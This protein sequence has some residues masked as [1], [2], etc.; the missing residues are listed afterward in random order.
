MLSWEP[1]K[2]CAYFLA[3]GHKWSRAQRT[4]ESA[5]YIVEAFVWHEAAVAV[6]IE[7]K[8]GGWPVWGEIWSDPT[9]T[10]GCQLDWN[11]EFRRLREEW[12]LSLRDPHK[13]GVLREDP[14]FERQYPALYWCLTS[15]TGLMNR[16]RERS[17]LNVWVAGD[18]W[19][20]FVRDMNTRLLM[21]GDGPTF[22]DL[23]A[24]LDARLAAGSAG[25]WRRD[26]YHHG[27]AGRTDEQGT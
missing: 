19:K 16:P 15:D 12:S 9:L 13:Y 23:L 7:T 2:R 1:L 11:I 21:W 18:R 27:N 10:F 14:M 8:K 3:R 5:R 4:H 26:K 17:R 24:Q 20:G 6:Q 22:D 25:L